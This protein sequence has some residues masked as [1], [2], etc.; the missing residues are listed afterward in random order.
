MANLTDSILDIRA[1]LPEFDLLL[2]VD[3]REGITHAV[4]D[5]IT[6][7]KQTDKTVAL[8]Y[9]NAMEIVKP[10]TTF[11]SLLSRLKATVEDLEANAG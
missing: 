3:E 10:K 4:S 11:T 1:E 2:V 8:F 9:R 5:A 7:A 6:T